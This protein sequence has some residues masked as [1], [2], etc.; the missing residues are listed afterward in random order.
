[1]LIPLQT[2]H[3]DMILPWRN[4]DNVRM[5]SFTDHIITRDEHYN[6]WYRI[7]H[8]ASRQWLLFCPDKIPSGV[9]NFYD[10]KPDQEASWGFYLADTLKDHEKLR[11]WFLLEKTV[12]NYASDTLRLNSL[13]C[14]LFASN[15]AALFMH[16]RSGFR[17][18]DTWKHE[19]GEVIVMQMTLNDKKNGSANGN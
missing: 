2:K 13:K 9:V 18:I 15:K 12:V 17:K 1:M 19:K 4:Q 8:D 11:L 3:L 16:K 10:I 6:W 7:R 5:N 14:E